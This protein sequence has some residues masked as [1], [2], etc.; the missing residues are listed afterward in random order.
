VKTVVENVTETSD[1]EIVLKGSSEPAPRPWW[2]HEARSDPSLGRVVVVLRFADS[3]RPVVH[4]A[5]SVGPPRHEQSDARQT[6]PGRFV[7]ET[8]PSGDG[9]LKIVV[10]DAVTTTRPV[11]V[12]AGE[13]TEVAVEIASGL[14]LTGRVALAELPKSSS[15]ALVAIDATDG[16]EKR[17]SIGSD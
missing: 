1:L 17:Y 11:S 10:N 12:A 6:A 8:V 3:G 9:L 13:T 14:A 2:E 16:D 15:M 4:A 5:L 7:V